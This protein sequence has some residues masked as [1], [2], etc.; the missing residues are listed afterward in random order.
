MKTGR[1][2]HPV[3]VPSACSGD[4]YATVPTVAP[5][6]VSVWSAVWVV[7]SETLFCILLARSKQLGQTE[8]QDLGLAAPGYEDIGGLDVAVNDAFG[9]RGIETIGYLDARSRISSVSIRFSA[10]RCFRVWPSMN[11]IAM[12][13]R[14]SILV[15]VV[16]GADVGVIH[17]RGRLRL[18][19]EAFQHMPVSGDF[20]GQK[21]EGNRA[22]EPGIFRF[23]DDAHPS[24]A[25]LFDDPIVRNGLTDALRSRLHPRAPVFPA[26]CR[27]AHPSK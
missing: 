16:N 12:K 25:Q 15:D 10:M 27:P 8:I 18:A 24:L 23:I 4:M 22:L 14:P 3:P 26:S 20:I 1:S 13:S 11:S 17:G 6:L 2:G 9:V 21:L 5:G 7:N 19:P